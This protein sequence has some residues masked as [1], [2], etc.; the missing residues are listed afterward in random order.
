[1]LGIGTCSS[2]WG[3]LSSL[4]TPG[5]VAVAAFLLSWNKWAKIV[6]LSIPPSLS[7]QSC[8]QG[9]SRST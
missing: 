2:K 3:D 6:A 4:F 5:S 7:E 1:V 8:E 9:V